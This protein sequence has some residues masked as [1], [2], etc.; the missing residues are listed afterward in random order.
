MI[1]LWLV[2]CNY[3]SNRTMCMAIVS[4]KHSISKLVFYYVKTDFFFFI[5]SKHNLYNS[6]SIGTS[7]TTTNNNKKTQMF[8]I[9]MWPTSVF[10]VI[11]RDKNLPN[12]ITLREKKIKERKQLKTF[13]SALV[14]ELNFS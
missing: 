9:H 6:I 2:H 5:R 8:F 12:H 4:N 14:Y 7:N 11:A 10:L 13:T 3:V 1:D